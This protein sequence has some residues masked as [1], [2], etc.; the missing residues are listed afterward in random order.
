MFA[1][2]RKRSDLDQAI[3]LYL[4]TV[5]GDAPIRGVLATPAV[6]GPL[7]QFESADARALRQQKRYWQA[8]R[9]ARLA[10]LFGVLVVPIE[11]LPLTNWLPSWSPAV[12]NALRGLT[13]LFM[14]VAIILLGL[15]RSALRWKQARG[16]AEQARGEVFRSIIAAGADARVLDQALACF[17]TA[18]L[19]WQLGFYES[20]LRKLPE[21]IRKEMSWTAPFRLVGIAVSI[22]A[23]TLG[24]VA[25]LK[26]LAAEGFLRPDLASALLAWF[27]EPAR[28]Q[29]GLNATA[30]SLLAFAGARFLTHE[31]LSSAVLYPWAR[32]E[33]KRLVSMDL[34]PAEAAAA[35]GE[36]AVV[37]EFCD[38]VQ[39]VLDTEHGVWAS[40]G[41]QSS[42]ASGSDKVK[43]ASASPAY[44]KA[45]AGS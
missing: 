30:S 40:G 36:A 27:P 26:F 20:R 29:H 6:R 2:N 45:L 39:R 32:T 7:A 17:R 42:W 12:V 14:F 11:L 44:G 16:E 37:Q 43:Q 21:R 38:R 4:A 1:F 10:A 3:E 18:H 13:L 5:P 15:R 23:A 31:D 24:A 25:L 28:W 22:G 34:K 19:D 41:P 8:G 35:R 33:L 9:L